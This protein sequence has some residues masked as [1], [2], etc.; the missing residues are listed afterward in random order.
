MGFGWNAKGTRHQWSGPEAKAGARLRGRCLDGCYRNRRP[1]EGG[2]LHSHT[3]RSQ[4]RNKE[5]KIKKGTKKRG[6]AASWGSEKGRAG[7]THK[8]R[9]RANCTK[10][11]VSMT[12]AHEGRSPLASEAAPI[13]AEAMLPYI[14]FCQSK[15]DTKLFQNGCSQS[16]RFLPQASRI[17]GS[18]DENAAVCC[19]SV[20][21]EFSPVTHR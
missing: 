18:G 8:Q 10:V 20:S 12:K 6:G 4:W 14:N 1:T 15:I 5:T 2:P 19:N 11:R 13:A 3:G 21:P 17:V 16:S 9:P 7:T